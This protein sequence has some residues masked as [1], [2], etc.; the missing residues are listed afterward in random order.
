MDHHKNLAGIV[1]TCSTAVKKV[2]ELFF[3]EHVLCYVLSGK[4]EMFNGLTHR[5]FQA[6]DLF[7]NKRNTL[8]KFLKYP[9][10][11]VPYKSISFVLDKQF[12]VGHHQANNHKFEYGQVTDESILPIPVDVLLANFL[13][14]LMPWFDEKIPEALIDLKKQEAVLL[15]L[16]SSPSLKAVLFDYNDPGKIDLQ[17]F[18][19][20]HFKF[21]VDIPQLAYLTGRSHATFKRDFE[22]IF[23]MTPHLLRRP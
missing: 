11:G 3:K 17:A 23:R 15:M 7:L 4:I 22:K 18:M 16:K 9:V 13:Q 19:H 8:G 5:V 1:F 14:S 2:S 12:L 10:D 6:G 20:Q 21:H